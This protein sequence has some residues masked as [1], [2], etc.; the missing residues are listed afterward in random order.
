[1]LLNAAMFLFLA[2]IVI[3]VFAFLS[4]NTWVSAPSKERLARDRFALLKTLAEQ[5]GE[6]AAR[7]LQILQNEDEERIQR[8]QREERRGWIDGGLILIALGLG[9]GGML[10]LFAN[11]T[12]WPVGLIP[13]FLGCALLAIGLSRDHKAHTPG[14]GAR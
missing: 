9:L 7:V 5:P 6:N 8:R 10:A 2:A 1:M 4:I 12:E 11:R 14:Q 3:S 13:F